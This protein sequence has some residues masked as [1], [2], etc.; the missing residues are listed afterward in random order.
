MSTREEP[1]RLLLWVFLGILGLALAVGVMGAWTGSGWH[2]GGMMVVG[3]LFMLLPVLLIVFLIYAV[4]DRGRS[5]AEPAAATSPPDDP[6]ALAI[7]TERYAAGE[8]SRDEFLQVKE[9]IEQAIEGD[10]EP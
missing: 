10:P 3:P 2:W 9:D 6:D 1:A 4:T 8:I 7:L 5:R